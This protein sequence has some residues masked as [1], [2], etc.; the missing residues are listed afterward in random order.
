MWRQG[1]VLFRR[2]KELPANVVRQPSPV[3]AEGELTGHAHRVADLKT[4]EVYV[5]LDGVMY[6]QVSAP[7][8]T[9]IHQEHGPITLCQGSYRVWKQREYA[10]E[11]RNGLGY[12]HLLD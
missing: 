9:I 4:A 3:L 5:G 10:P 6:L 1:D 7:E 12:R 8:A 11:D 2:V